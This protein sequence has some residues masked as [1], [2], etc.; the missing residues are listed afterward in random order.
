VQHI[1]G[2]TTASDGT[3]SADIHSNYWEAWHISPNSQISDFQASGTYGYDD[4]FMIN[5]GPGVHGDDSTTAT[6]AF[7]EGLTLPP[8]FTPGGVRGAGSLPSTNINPNLP[9]TNATPSVVRTFSTS[10]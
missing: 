6:A 8:S 2:H 1:Q 3:Q 7:Y 10:F 4:I 9:Q 5:P